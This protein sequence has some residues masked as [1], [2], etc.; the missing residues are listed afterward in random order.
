MALRTTLLLLATGA[1][2]HNGTCP[3]SKTCGADAGSEA[4]LPCCQTSSTSFECCSSSEACI[5]KVGCRCAG[6]ENLREYQGYS[7]EDYQQEFS[8]SYSAGEL[9]SRKA[10]FEANLRKVQA[11]NAEYRQGRH[12]WFMAMN[13]L[14]DLSEEEFGSK[15]ATKLGPA[16][17]RP[18]LQLDAEDRK[19]NPTAMD[20]R[21]K[22][23]VTPVKDQGGCGSCWAFSATE[24]VES[25]YAIA[26]GKLLTL[27][28]QTYVDCVQNPHECGGTGGC[29]GA[30]MEL[31]FNLTIS[32]GI[33]LESAVPYLGRDESCPSYKAAVKAKSYVRLPINDASA[34]ETALATKGPMSVTVAADSWQLYG[35]GIF[36]GCSQGS[37]NTLDHGVQAVGYAK[38][39]W[40]VRI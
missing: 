30:T 18:M 20:W 35:G 11:H 9:E 8:K 39:Y 37:S 1:A 13:E 31:A 32:K 16:D 15:R 24:T 19:P 27:S 21:S 25:H 38:D 7:F 12:T 3:S 17:G 2:A 14:A 4:G 5:P 22:G 23:V 28:P 6:E 26:S 40:L 36:Q 34:L 10:I 33:A 29:E